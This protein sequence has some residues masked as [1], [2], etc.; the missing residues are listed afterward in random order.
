MGYIPIA[1]AKREERLAITGK[2][3]TESSSRF[4]VVAVPEPFCQGRDASRVALSDERRVDNR[5]DTNARTQTHV[6]ALQQ[7]LATQGN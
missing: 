7:A 4:E 6:R 5:E 3:G 1:R 2:R